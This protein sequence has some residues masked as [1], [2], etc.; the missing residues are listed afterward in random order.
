MKKTHLAFLSTLLLSTLL[1]LQASADILSLW[2]RGDGIYLTGDPALD[3]FSDNTLGPGYGIAAGMEILFIDLM[4][5][6]NFFPDGAQ[7]NQLGIGF[8][9]DLLPMPEI[10]ISPTSQFFYYFGKFDDGRESIKGFHARAG[11]QIGV[12]FAKYFWFNLEGYTGY[13]L[14]TPDVGAGFVY[15]G[16]ANLTFKIDI[17]DLFSDDDPEETIPVETERPF[18]AKKKTQS[19]IK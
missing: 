12:N 2:V 1:S 13:L 8:D 5:D 17:L 3:Y 19:P 9:A 6:A 7:F 10:H 15:S 18:P 14:T 16:G 4:F 11:L